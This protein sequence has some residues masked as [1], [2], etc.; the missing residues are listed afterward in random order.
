MTISIETTKV[1][2]AGDG[3]D[4]VFAYPFR[5]L[6]DDDLLVIVT[7]DATLV[8]NTLTLNADYTVSGAG[9]PAGGNVILSAGSKC[10]S[11]YTLT[12]LR[13]MA[14]TQETD[15][16]DGDAFSAE[17]IENALDKVTMIQQ[18]QR[19]ELIRTPK[20]PRT[21]TI[22]D[23]VL[24][25]PS[26][27]NY[28]GWNAAATGLENKAGQVVT[29]ATQYE[30]DALVSFGGGTS[31]T[32]AT[33]QAALTAIGTSNKVT[34]LLRPGTWVISS[35]ADWSAY[36]NV[37][38]K[39][40]PGAV[41]SHGAFTVNLPNLDAGLYTVFSGTGI[42]TLSGA[43]NEVQSA[44][45]GFSSGSTAAVNKAAIIAAYYLHRSWRCQIAYGCLFRC[46]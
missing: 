38:F 20:L 42:V 45:F 31:Y 40:V 2:Y 33:I 28:I 30:I 37:T 29:T 16:V 36:T 22:T 18:Q 7:N 25:N 46:R 32:Q 14:A 27:N 41:I 19:E 21:S 43:L 39:I 24:P 15:Y 10:G 17:S 4:T 3:I 6:K 23:I 26:A 34:L 35:N 9:V 11:G 5:I 1:Q 44:W 8:E 12:I 13:N